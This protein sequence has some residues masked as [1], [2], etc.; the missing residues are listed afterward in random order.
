M[1]ASN[2]PTPRDARTDAPKKEDAV[3]GFILAITELTGF[4]NV[5]RWDWPNISHWLPLP[6]IPEQ[7]SEAE[8]AFED[9]A[10]KVIHGRSTTTKEDFIAGFNAAKKGGVA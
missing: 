5:C 2:Y 1:N 6:P 9:Y 8:R 10:S 3:Q 7:K 4:W